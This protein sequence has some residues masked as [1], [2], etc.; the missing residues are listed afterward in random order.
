MQRAVAVV[1]LATPLDKIIIETLVLMSNL[2]TFTLHYSHFVQSGNKN[3]KQHLV[4]LS[5]LC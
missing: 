1:T 2:P 5:T 4:R 3:T